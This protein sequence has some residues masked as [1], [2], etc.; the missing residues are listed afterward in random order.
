MKDMIPGNSAVFQW[1]YLIQFLTK[2]RYP[3]NA[4]GKF[5][6]D[7]EPKSEI[8]IAVKCKIKLPL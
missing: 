6:M 8:I 4:A 7:I 5:N 2:E 3:I 1:N